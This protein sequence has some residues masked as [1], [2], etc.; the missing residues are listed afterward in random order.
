MLG[1]LISGV[2]YFGINMDVDFATSG[3]MFANSDDVQIKIKEAFQLHVLT[4]GS[5]SAPLIVQNVNGN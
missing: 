4:L 5:F 3:E 2:K 1:E